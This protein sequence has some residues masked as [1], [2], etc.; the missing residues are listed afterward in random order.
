MVAYNPPTRICYYIRH[1]ANPSAQRP[2]RPDRATPLDPSPCSTSEPTVTEHF[3]CHQRAAT[4]R[5]A[6]FCTPS[7]SEESTA[8]EVDAG[9]PAASHGAPPNA[10]SIGV[11]KCATAC[12]PIAWW[13]PTFPVLMRSPGGAAHDDGAADEPPVA[14]ARK[15]GRGR[16]AGERKCDKCRRK[17]LTCGPGC[18]GW[19]ALHPGASAASSSATAP[20]WSGCHG[21]A[22]QAVVVTADGDPTALASERVE[23]RRSGSKCRDCVREKA[24]ACFC[25]VAIRPR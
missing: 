10:F 14:T 3:G 25:L 11:Q 24:L 1:R 13:H 12:K 7:M 15:R 21:A 8:H 17:S 5:L 18:A 2:G 23:V 20:A 22:S 4:V 19:A 16:P 9:E 6:D